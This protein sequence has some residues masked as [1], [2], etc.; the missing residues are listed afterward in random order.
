MTMQ[1]HH[2]EST[3]TEVI[4]IIIDVLMEIDGGEE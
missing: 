2:D 3:D 1:H 4:D